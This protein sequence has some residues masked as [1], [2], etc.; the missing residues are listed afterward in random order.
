MSD[1]P[2]SAIPDDPAALHARIAALERTVVLLETTLREQT[3]LLQH[4]SDAIIVTDCRAPFLIQRWEGGA[5]R[6]YGW[7]AGEAIGQSLSDLIG[8]VRYL[9]ETTTAV[10]LAALIAQ[11]QWTGMVFHR[12]RDG[13]ELLVEL[14][15]H[16]RR[17]PDGVPETLVAVSRDVTER[18]R[19][20]QAQAHLAAIV[21]SSPEAIMSTTPEGTVVSWNAGAE[22]VYGYSAAEVIGQSISLIIPAELR[23]ELDGLYARLR[24]GERIALFET[25]RV[26]KD[27]RRIA[28]A[29][30]ISPVLNL[31]GTVSGF[32]AIARDITERKQVEAVLHQERDFSTAVLDTVGALVIVLDRDGR[33]VR[34]N[35]ACEQLTG[36]TFDE[37]RGQQPWDL[38]LLPEEL[39]GVQATFADL[40]AGHFPNSYENAWRTR[41]GE[42]RQIS[43]ANTVLCDATGVPE[44]IIGTGIDI[45]E[46]QRAMAALRESEAKFR[47]LF[48]SSMFGIMLCELN[49]LIWEANDAFL[50]MLGYTRDELVAGQLDWRQLTSSEFAAADEYAC[51]ELRVFG[52]STPFEKAYRRKDGTLV[53]VLIGAVRVLDRPQS[54]AAYVVD[55]TERK[56][57][58]MQLA[59]AQRMDSVGRLAG[60]IA[61]DFNNLLA[62]IGGYTELVLETLAPGDPLWVDLV[63]VRKATTRAAE[64]TRQL[65]TFA[66]KQPN[67]PQV[68]DLA[69]S[70]HELAPLLRQAVGEAIVLHMQTA[71]D[72]W[73]VRF[74]LGQIE[75]VLLNLALNARD[76][77]PEGGTL[78]IT[79]QNVVLDT[80]EATGRGG[81]V[82]GEYVRIS[83]RDTGVGMSPE[84][85]AKAFE[86]FFTTKGPKKGSG[87]GLASCYGIVRQHGGTIRL[88]SQV[89]RGTTVQIDLPR[90]LEPVRAQETADQAVDL[91]RGTE[92]VLLVEDNDAVRAL[93]ARIL[94]NLGYT[95]LEAPDGVVALEVAANYPNPIQL[96]LS[97]VVMPHLGGI[98][99]AAR[100]SAERPKLKL[101]LMSGYAGGDATGAEQEAAWPCLDKPFTSQ[102]L[103]QVVRAVL[104]ETSIH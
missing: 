90:A 46:Q 25:V 56:R 80:W 15:T 4:V 27:G 71:P 18:V 2:L 87:L 13:H 42:R 92:T 84:V 59:Q 38:L 43:W 10:A 88:V 57:L 100:L 63:E 81:V 83:V 101:I 79:L 17:G 50:S 77:M 74:D 54:Y 85:Q 20:A 53:P 47:S 26:R 52:H 28:V 94:R 44:F 14:A 55:L 51:A 41:K 82:P 95:V 7:S 19:A 78:T 61:H 62:A 69:S 103:A 22:Q 58:E 32:A 67:A 70:I 75:Q 37:M 6:I 5:A 9:D 104:D 16:V 49:G 73:L 3:I 33:I 36:Y 12:H 76:A 34:F 21:E 35:R 98:A 102:M 99:L 23:D 91:P 45:T 30:T 64:L 11:G 48:T 66:R 39:A 65:L 93:A 29:L 31:E 60:G 96:V 1:L 89:G 8:S 97:D 40:C 68:L 24:S 72:L 86:P